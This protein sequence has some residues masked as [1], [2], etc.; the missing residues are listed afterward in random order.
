MTTGASAG[1]AGWRGSR[2]PPAAR[3][4]RKQK[5]GVL[6]GAARPQAVEAQPCPR[7]SEE[8]TGTEI[9]VPIELAR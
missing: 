3:N 2:N 4:E 1:P 6:L 8:E 9:H 5:T 7:D